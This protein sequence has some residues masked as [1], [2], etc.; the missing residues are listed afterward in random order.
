M[1]NPV[2]ITR[3]VCNADKCKP[4][5]QRHAHT[6]LWIETFDPAALFVILHYTSIVPVALRPRMDLML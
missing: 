4:T 1:C 6:A 3:A 5:G 2:T